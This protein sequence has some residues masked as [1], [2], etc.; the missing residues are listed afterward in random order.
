MASGAPVVWCFCVLR[1]C[2]GTWCTSVFCCK[3]HGFH[4]V[5]FVLG[6]CAYMYSSVLI[7][8]KHEVSNIFIVVKQY[9]SDTLPVIEYDFQMF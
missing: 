2:G 9:V 6:H 1:N 8:L 5:L 3:T 4:G 7:M